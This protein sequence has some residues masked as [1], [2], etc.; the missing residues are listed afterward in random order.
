MLGKE[1]ST[2]REN[3]VQNLSV[4]FWCADIHVLWKETKIEQ[5]GERERERE[6]ESECNSRFSMLG[7][8][9]SVQCSHCA[10]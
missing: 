7:F 5:E 1:E 3:V 2:H 9:S 4:Q 6:S 10:V 8:Y